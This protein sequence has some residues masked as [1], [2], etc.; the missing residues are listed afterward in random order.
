MEVVE[1]GVW[2]ATAFVAADLQITDWDKSGVRFH[3]AT[4]HE[5]AHGAMAAQGVEMWDLVVEY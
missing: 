1:A 4:S 2:S 5:W 3:P